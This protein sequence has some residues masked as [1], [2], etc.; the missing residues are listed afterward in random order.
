MN[1]NESEDILEWDKKNITRFA[2]YLYNL[3]KEKVLEEKEKAKAVDEV[4]KEAPIT[5]TINEVEAKKIERKIGL[6]EA[7]I[8]LAKAVSGEEI[9]EELNL[10]DQED[11]KKIIEKEQIPLPK[12]EAVTVE[13]PPESKPEIITASEILKEV[14]KP[15]FQVEEVKEEPEIEEIKLEEQIQNLEP[16]NLSQ[17]IVTE[18]VINEEVLLKPEHI[19][20]DVHKMV[21]IDEASSV[22]ITEE[23][24]IPLEIETPVTDEKVDLI[25]EQTSPIEVVAEVSQI[26]EPQVEEVVS[27]EPEASIEPII[28][29]TELKEIEP[30]PLPET[31]FVSVPEPEEI[32]EIDTAEV[33]TDS[34]IEIEEQV[35]VI[36]DLDD[37]Q[38]KRRE[39]IIQQM[40]AE[41]KQREKEEEFNVKDM[42]QTEGRAYS[43]VVFGQESSKN[44]KK[45]KQWERNKDKREK[46]LAKK[47]AKKEQRKKK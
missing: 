3:A 9:E 38:V 4:T 29:T 41:T 42:G 46:K 35:E 39:E 34:A 12:E 36:P 21:F 13:E 47:E 45:W 16:V 6:E 24:I 23:E 20:E 14:E 5:E 10:K 37:E 44:V 30:E 15:E 2:Q 17:P 8:G 32:S 25:A 19:P 1:S 33:S 43:A 27:F 28:E 22:P 26:E 7:T 11:L 40:L 31:E 18:P